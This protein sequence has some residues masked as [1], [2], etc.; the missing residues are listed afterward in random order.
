MDEKKKI[1]LSIIAPLLLVYVLWMVKI[2]EK[3]SGLHFGLYGII[4]RNIQGLPGIIT[5]PFIHSGY[6]HL[7]SNSI[8]V[9][10]LGMALVYF[11]RELALKVSLILFAATGVLV[12]F[13]GRESS[14]IGASGFVYGLASFLFFSGAIR[15]HPRLL[16]ISLLVT[17]LYGGMIWGVFPIQPGISWESH[18][19]GAVTGGACAILFRKEGLQKEQHVWDDEDNEPPDEDEENPEQPRDE[20]RIRY[21]YKDRGNPEV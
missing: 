8:P 6:A 2:A 5:G 12:W 10:L 11:Y 9:F 19:S 4:P 16:T 13:I 18:L 7:I 1:R 14:H 17:F 3:M 21:I 15:K 20:V